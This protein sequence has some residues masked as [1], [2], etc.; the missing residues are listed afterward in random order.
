M[1]T[2][3]RCLA[4]TNCSIQ[5]RTDPP[6]LLQVCELPYWDWECIRGGQPAKRRW[7]ADCLFGPDY[8]IDE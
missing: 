5:Y 7:L 4:V 1:P 3:S 6:A 8:S 2:A